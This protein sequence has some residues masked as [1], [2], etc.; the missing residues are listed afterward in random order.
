MTERMTIFGYPEPLGDADVANF[1]PLAWMGILSRDQQCIAISEMNR[2]RAAEDMLTARLAERDALLA[3]A[4]DELQA[5]H[6]D[7][8]GTHEDWKLIA[9]ESILREAGRDV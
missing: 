3:R 6:S 2:A 7:R 4:L 5:V 8:S 9:V 1:R